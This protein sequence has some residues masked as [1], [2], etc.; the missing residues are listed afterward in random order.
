MARKPALALLGVTL[1]SVFLLPLLAHYA[2]VALLITLK[3][4]GI[5][6]FRGNNNEDALSWILSAGQ[7]LAVLLTLIFT[8]SLLF[9]WYL[10]MRN[11]YVKYFRT[12]KREALTAMQHNSIVTLHCKVK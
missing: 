6:Q 3:N 4:A 12:H 7:L 5:V 9:A 11:I 10:G 1:A 8:A 2:I